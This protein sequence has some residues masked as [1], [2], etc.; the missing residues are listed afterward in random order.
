MK[1]TILLLL[2]LSACA[3]VAGQAN[4]SIMLKLNEYQ[5]QKKVGTIVQI[6]GALTVSATMVAV[7]NG[8]KRSGYEGRNTSKYAFY[9]SGIFMF[10]VAIKIDANINLRRINRKRK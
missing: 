10:G 3:T 1:N 6:V 7:V 9:S 8:M 4:D 5:R 2:L